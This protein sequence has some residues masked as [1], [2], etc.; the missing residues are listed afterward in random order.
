MTQQ[1]GGWTKVLPLPEAGAAMIR[2]LPRLLGQRRASIISWD[3]AVL[4]ENSAD[5]RR[6]HRTRFP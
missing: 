6:L 5:I 3:S 4:P 2:P 1:A